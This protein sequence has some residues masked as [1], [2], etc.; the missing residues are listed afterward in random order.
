MVDTI[1]IEKKSLILLDDSNYYYGFKRLPWKLDYEKFYWWVKNSFDVLDIYFFGGMITKKTFFDRHPTH[2]LSGFIQ[3]KETR[4]AFF[5]LLKKTGYKVRTKPVASLYD[6]TKGEY[7]RKCNFDVEITIIA[8]DRLNE[9]KELIL[10]SGDGDFTKLL[11]YVKGKYKKTTLIVHKDR[12]NWD[13]EKTA[14]RV[15]F[16]ESLRRDVQK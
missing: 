9:Y 7:R 12:L 2:T 6:S 15:I 3:Y 14:N 4:Q 10:C 1:E 16:V 11:K 5:N 13:L 8:L